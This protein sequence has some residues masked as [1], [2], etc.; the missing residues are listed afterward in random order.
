[1]F[2][3]GFW[4]ED[5]REERS[6]GLAYSPVLARA[7]LTAR[8]FSRSGEGLT[9]RARRSRRVKAGHGLKKIGEDVFAAAKRGRALTETRGARRGKEV[10]V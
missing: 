9:L 4:V 6:G 10:D 7:C 8:G 1:M 3:F 5:G 2:N